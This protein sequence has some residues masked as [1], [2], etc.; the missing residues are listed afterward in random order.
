ML[1][2]R[3]EIENRAATRREALPNFCVKIATIIL[4]DKKITGSFVILDWLESLFSHRKPK[5]R[6]FLVLPLIIP[7]YCLRTIPCHVTAFVRRHVY[8]P[9]SVN[10]RACTNSVY[11]ALL[12]PPLEPGNE[13]STQQIAII[14]SQVP[15][16]KQVCKNIK[17][18]VWSC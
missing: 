17:K 2:P 8:W 13:A 7:V 10:S 12:S 16:P 15:N 18:W 5:I 11:Q 6:Q 1:K 4:A 14:R 3:S 9:S